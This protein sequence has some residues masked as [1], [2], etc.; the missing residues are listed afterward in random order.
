MN[1]TFNDIIELKKH[2]IHLQNIAFKSIE[3]K[4]S[5]PLTV[6]LSD[7][8]EYEGCKKGVV[9]FVLKSQMESDPEAIYD[10]A[11]DVKVSLMY[12]IKDKEI[13]QEEI[14]ELFRKNSNAILNRTPVYDY[15][16]LLISQI[17]SAFGKPPLVFYRTANNN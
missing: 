10:L 9:V 17:T 3:P 16:S 14:D 15:L 13:T 12:S 7:E 6:T 4:K 8:I 5:G 2:S 11:I 1:K